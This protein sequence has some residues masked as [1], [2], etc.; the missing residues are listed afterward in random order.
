MARIERYTF[1]EIVIDGQAYHDDLIILPDRIIPSW[2]R[3]EGH[4]LA[5]ED[6]TEV[7]KSRPVRF[8]MGCG[9]YGALHVP[10]ATR[11]FLREQGIELIAQPTQQAV[12]TFNAT[13]DTTTACGLHLTC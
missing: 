1:G 12:E 2:W 10:R 11:D 9:A 5:P 8:I 3:K 4:S 13:A 7:I 6:L